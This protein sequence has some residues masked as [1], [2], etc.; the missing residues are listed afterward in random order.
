MRHG[1]F[2]ALLLLTLPSQAAVTNRHDRAILRVAALSAARAGFHDTPLSDALG[3]AMIEATGADVALLP[4]PL[5]GKGDLADRIPADLLETTTLTGADLRALLERTARGFATYDFQP[6]RSAG[7]SD[8]AVDEI[9]GLSYELDLTRP[10]GERVMH[11]AFRG[12]SLGTGRSLEVAVSQSRAARGDR[13]LASARAGV[14]PI[15]LREAVVAHV[16][17][18]PAPAGFERSWTV[19]PD[20]LPDVERPLI[21]RLVREGAMPR[22]E[23]L[24]VFPDEMAR[25]GELAYW[26]ARAFGWQERRLSGAYSDVPDSLQPWVDALARHHVLDLETRTSELFQPFAPL[27]LSIALDWCAHAAKS[28]RGA[29]QDESALRHALVANTSLAQRPLTAPDTLSRAQALGIV[30]NARFLGR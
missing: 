18:A 25:R 20:Y 30:A 13:E 5:E 17:R 7:L 19:L 29:T 24:R 8:S 12:E 22:D 14:S 15:P 26:L 11:L 2:A 10:P 1:V 6:R 4:A 9:H 28:A 3:A 27:T 23:A 21:D 16:E